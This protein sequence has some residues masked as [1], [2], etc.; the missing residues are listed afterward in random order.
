MDRQYASAVFEVVHE[1]PARGS[2]ESDA[3][4]IGG[5]VIAD[6]GVVAP[7]ADL[8]IPADIVG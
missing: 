1:R 6:G 7:C 8:E 2:R 3:A 5:V 4:V